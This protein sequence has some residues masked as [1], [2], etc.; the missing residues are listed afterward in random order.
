M[1][2]EETPTSE[3]QLL[4]M[5]AD[6][7]ASLWNNF[8]LLALATGLAFVAGVATALLLPSS[9]RA[10]TE[11]MP[12]PKQGK[13][14]LLSAM[15]S[16]SG[17][18]SSLFG[19]GSSSSVP[20][21]ETI[22]R[23]RSM[24]FHVIQKHRLDTVWL[25]DGGWK[26]A[27][28]ENL[29]MAWNAS[30]SYEITE[31][32][33]I[34]LFFLD[35]DSVRATLVVSSA[36]DFLDS[37]YQ[38]YQRGIARQNESFLQA[39]LD[40]RQSLLAEA[41]DSLLAFQIANKAFLPSAQIEAQAKKAALDQVEIEKLNIMIELEKKT[42]GVGARYQELEL[43][44]K[45]KEKTLAAAFDPAGAV[46]GAKGANPN[47]ISLT[48]LNLRFQRLLRQI[49]IHGKVFAFLIQQ[50][51]QYTLDAN[52]DIPAL[53]IIDAP[54]VP[55]KRAKPPRATVV[56]AFTLFGFL[57]AWGSIVIWPSA[58]KLNAMVA[59]KMSRQAA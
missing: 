13:G 33:G 35:K 2:S 52:K 25:P 31:Y 45:E 42:D 57:G 43:L 27:R 11:L 49:E 38:V 54:K 23:S 34:K 10:D 24:A 48:R 58:R 18:I 26:K 30:F 53:T 29:L 41:E 17:D 59:K 9:Y 7:I 3:L 5:I 47:L 32:D 22:L 39:Q 14:G 19:G 55:R 21:F 56:M 15:A 20:L 16:G 8:R 51:E 40:K 37:A 4:E 44:R 28:W 1:N 46:R 6:V 36:T 50:K 12:P